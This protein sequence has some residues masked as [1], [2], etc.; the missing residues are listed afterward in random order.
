MCHAPYNATDHHIAIYTKK[1]ANNKNQKEKYEIDVITLKT[2]EMLKINS[3]LSSQ[4]VMLHNPKINP[5]DVASDLSS[6]CKSW[7]DVVNDKI[8][9]NH[10]SFHLGWSLDYCFG[11]FIIGVIY[12]IKIK[13]CF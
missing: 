13:R 4:R 2:L 8:M 6:S 11:L 3:D 1:V 10:L 7:D 9:T 5:N 12:I